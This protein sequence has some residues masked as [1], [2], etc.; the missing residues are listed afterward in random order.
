MGYQDD[1][2]GVGFDCEDPMELP[3]KRTLGGE[4]F[5]TFHTTVEQ[6][7]TSVG[8]GAGQIEVILTL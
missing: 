2:P 8:N 3:D 1:E 4:N 5:G 6:R 7:R